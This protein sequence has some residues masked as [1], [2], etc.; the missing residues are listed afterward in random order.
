M[1]WTTGLGLEFM[2]RQLLFSDT[3]NAPDIAL[4]PRGRNTN[5]TSVLHGDYL[6][7]K[8]KNY[9]MS[10]KKRIAQ[11]T[12]VT[13]SWNQAKKAEKPIIC[14]QLS[15]CNIIINLILWKSLRSI[16]QHSQLPMCSHFPDIRELQQTTTATATKT[17]GSL[18]HVGFINLNIV[19][20][21]IT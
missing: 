20:I 8:I 14:K 12:D 5:S 3:V 11:E 4:T 1:Q 13:Y 7:K 6:V 18:G 17:S 10:P 19:L 15:Q 16:L 21:I 2:A 9:L